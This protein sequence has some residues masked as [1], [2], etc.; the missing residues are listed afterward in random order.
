MEVLVKITREGY[1][2]RS[3]EGSV[4]CILERSTKNLIALIEREDDKLIATP[5]DERILASIQLPEVDSVYY[6][7]QDSLHIGN[8]LYLAFDYEDIVNDYLNGT[9][10]VDY[11]DILSS[12]QKVDES[13]VEELYQKIY[14]IEYR[15]LDQQGK[16]LEARDFFIRF[17]EQG[18]KSAISQLE[19][20]VEHR[21]DIPNKPP[22]L[23]Q[24]TL[25]NLE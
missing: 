11:L 13:E 12:Y 1:R 4:Q 18:V 17:A 7:E 9:K 21:E 23:V 10:T 24:S 14:E 20:L 3:P 6:F 25:F 22:V 8:V 2:R 5:L 15:Q 16:T 19:K